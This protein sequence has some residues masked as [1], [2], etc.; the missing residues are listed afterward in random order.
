MNISENFTSTEFTVALQH[1]KPGKPRGHNSICLEVILHVGAAL[2][3]WLYGFLSSCLSRVKIL[4]ICRR[5]LVV[6]IPKP[7]KSVEDAKSYRLIFLLCFPNQILKRL[8]HARVEAI[9][10]PQPSREQAEF[11]HGRSTVDQTVLLT[12]NIEDSFEAKKKAVAVFVNLTAAY[13]TVWHRGLTCKLL[14]LLPDK[15]MVQMI[16]E[17]IRNRS[18]TLTPSDSK[19]S[20]LRRPNGVRQVSVLVPLFF[21]IYT[22]DLSST[23]SRKY[24]YADDL[25]LLHSSK[26]W[27]SLEE[28]LSQG[29]ATLSANCR[30]WK[31]KLSHTKTVTS[32]FYLHN[33]E[34]KRE[35]KVYANGKLLPFCP[36]PTYLGAKLDQSLTFRHPLETLRKKLATRVRLLRPLAGPG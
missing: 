25:A 1:L 18:F 9:I 31:L 17:F 4:K 12:Q 14:R 29:M 6:A 32:A 21:N 19:R 22:Y 24:A 16:L 20:R 3:S 27:K 33:R 26:D 23:T 5:P 15:H 11:R 36:L 8:I 10:D 7:K 13:G 35:L 28:T 30:T 2:T 34:T